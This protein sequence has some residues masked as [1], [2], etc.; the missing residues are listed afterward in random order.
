MWLAPT[1]TVFDVVLACA[2]VV[3]V[4]A[5]HTH[6]VVARAKASTTESALEK[7]PPPRTVDQVFC[8]VRLLPFMN[9]IPYFLDGNRSFFKTR[10]PSTRASR[11][12]RMTLGAQRSL[13]M[14]LVGGVAL[15][16]TKNLRYVFDGLYVT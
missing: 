10:D 14:T 1:L 3:C 2:W 15:A 8:H 13:R 5:G 6:M 11:S 9:W 12:L 16:Q 4:A 7:R